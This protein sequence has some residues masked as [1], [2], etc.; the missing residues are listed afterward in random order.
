MPRVSRQQ[1]DNNRLAIEEA[2]SR[3][4]REQG[5]KAVSVADLMAAAGLTHGG[6]YGHF[7]SKDALAAVACARAFDQSAE[8]WEK[9]VA[10]KTES[11]AALAGLVEGYLSV[12][13]RN[14]PGSGCP[15]AGLATDVAREPADKPIHAAYV[16]GLKRLID[17]MLGAQ[18]EPGAEPDRGAGLAQMATLVGA[19][20]LARATRGDALSDEI[21]AAA[22]AHLL[23]V[24]AANSSPVDKPPRARK[25]PAV[26]KPVH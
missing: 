4:F 10:G 14:N 3:L 19:M 25:S 12:N 9:R 18:T 11:A 6:F 2:S 23:P 21:L 16:D 17:I 13:S 7:E 22:R 5:I 20:V 24:A 26:R 8:R 1:T 15:I